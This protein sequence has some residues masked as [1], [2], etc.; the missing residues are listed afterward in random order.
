M[1]H[2]RLGFVVLSLATAVGCGFIGAPERASDTQ[3]LNAIS[4]DIEALRQ[5]RNWAVQ[6][7]EGGRFGEIEELI[8]EIAYGEYLA[9]L[10]GG[11]AM[12]QGEFARPQ[13]L[14]LADSEIAPLRGGEA[15]TL[16]AGAAAARLRLGTVLA[17][18]GEGVFRDVG[19]DDPTLELVR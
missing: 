11:I 19:V 18:A 10:A 1:T 5:M 6:L 2:I 13:D 16:S 9:Q 14:G 8:L 17:E 12:A 3:N 7:D 15:G 4:D